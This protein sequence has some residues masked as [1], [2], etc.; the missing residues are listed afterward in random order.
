ML[1]K[2]IAYDKEILV[3]L[4]SLGNSYWDGFWLFVTNQ[5]YW[6]PVFLLILYLIFKHYGVKKGIAFILITAALVTFSDQFVNFTKNYFQRLRPN[7]D[8]VLSEII[9]LTKRPGS[10]SFLSGHST[11]SFAATTFIILT[12]RRHTKYIWFFILWPI[13][14]AYSRIYLGV[15]YPL[16]IFVGMIVGILIGLLFYRLSLWIL[17]RMEAG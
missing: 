3:Y 8:P 12:L 16:D 6:S 9:R 1:E 7:N 17:K 14:F 13:V 4:N 5:F 2:V 11:T 10:Y 15:H